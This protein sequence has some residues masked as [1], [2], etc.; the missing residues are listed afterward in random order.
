MIFHSL[1]SLPRASAAFVGFH[2]NR[3]IFL[4]TSRAIQKNEHHVAEAHREI[5]FVD[6]GEGLSSFVWWTIH[7][8]YPLISK[9]WR[10]DKDYT[11][12]DCQETA[13][14]LISSW[15]VSR[16]KRILAH[17]SINRTFVESYFEYTT[18]ARRIYFD[19]YI[20]RVIRNLLKCNEM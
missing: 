14:I 10:V 12:K 11:D 1:C 2:R 17:E 19:K 4:W 3:I 6:R 9:S 7:S 20:M 5:L 13:K 16:I 18:V 8:L 15:Y